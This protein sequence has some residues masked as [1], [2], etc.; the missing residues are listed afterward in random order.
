[1]EFGSKLTFSVDS[2]KKPAGNTLPP[3]ESRSATPDRLRRV[4]Y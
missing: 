2:S 4:E 3:S 1:M